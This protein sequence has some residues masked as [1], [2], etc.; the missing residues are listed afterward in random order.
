MKR[1]LLFLLLL[2]AGFAALHFALGGD[3]L[4]GKATR[5][6]EGPRLP[7]EADS[8]PAIKVSQGAEVQVRGGFTIGRHRDVARAE[9]GV[10]RQRIYELTCAD[11][12]AL[13]DGKHILREVRVQLFDRGAHA[14][15]LT[16]S[17]AV[18]ELAMDNRQQRSLRENRELE[19]EDAVLASVDGGRL[20]PLR[21]TVGRVLAQL[22]E[23]MIRLR[24]PSDRE[25]V[26]AVLD[27][28]RR[29]ELR[30][31]GLVASAPRDRSQGGLLDLRILHEPQVT[32]RGLQLRG[33]GELRYREDL[34][35]GMATIAMAGDIQADVEPRA[36]RGGSAEP[37]AVRG[38]RLAGLLQRSERGGSA[39]RSEL[40]WVGL[41]LF[42][43][44]ATVT[45][46]T[47]RIASPRL[48][49]LPGPDG[50][51]ESMIADG[52]ESELV[53][54]GP[55]GAEF[56]SRSP[57]RL[58]RTRSSI[59]ALHRSLGFPAHALGP[60]ADLEVLVFD[61]EASIRTD[62]GLAAT[63]SRGMRFYRR[64]NAVPDAPSLAL[65]FG[66]V[67]LAQTA[68]DDRIEATGGN[69]FV[70]RR[71][72]RG[73]EIQL[74]D[75]DP[76]ATQPF[77]IVR[78]G[79]ELRAQG[80]ATIRRQP[81]GVATLRL[82][83]AD[84]TI[85]GTFRQ[86]GREDVVHLRD[87]TALDAE[88]LAKEL[89]AFAAAGPRVAVD[90][91]R[92]GLTLQA[93]APR[94]ELL[95]PESWRLA[96][97][98]EAPARVRRDVGPAGRKNEFVG[99]LAAPTVLLHRVS[100]RSLAMEAFGDGDGLASIDAEDPDG[101][102]RLRANARRIV[103]LPFAVGPRSQVR[104]MLGLPPGAAEVVAGAMSQ[105]WLL[106]V[107]EVDAEFD[108][109]GQGSVLA[110]GLRLEAAL[111]S[112]A[113]LLHGDAAAR[114]PALLHRRENGVRTLTAEGPR[115]RF[116]QGAGERI[117]A[118]WRF[119]DEQEPLP[120][121]VTLYGESGQG[122]RSTG[123]ISGECQGEIEA[124][125]GAVEFRGPVTAHSLLPDGTVDPQGLAIDATRLRMVRNKATGTLQS[126]L[127]SE[128]VTLHW[129][130]LFA[131]SDKIEL[132][133]RWQRCIAEDPVGAEVRFGQGQ[134]Y[135]ARR[136]EANY[137]TY[138]VRSYFGS[139]QQ[140]AQAS[141]PR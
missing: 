103:L 19:L 55:K 43:Q 33:T 88:V 92:D 56:R 109:P 28:E 14:A 10:V 8:G 40:T 35:D 11:S 117:T 68:G 44:P 66:D 36:G 107:G 63:A 96:G 23:A 119:H 140:Q 129:N 22:D 86:P 69:G 29:G 111:G 127:A 13:P 116:A 104:S 120:P 42:G 30:G 38:Q 17:R 76:A 94:I 126:V 34:A 53:Q 91:V 118:L 83:S 2:G 50:G 95:T 97:S 130:D 71:D 110:E 122:A 112:Q 52:G 79:L 105:P 24:T 45:T 32:M 114:K 67:S 7:R 3:E 58:L 61:G 47:V 90:F 115:I 121:R 49:A 54:A 6:S 102:G 73:D 100:T 21:L 41:R 20:P 132:D 39:R 124:L 81:D 57:I 27:G 46:G 113:L 133:L 128:G 87:A 135:V 4:V 64:E 89:R 9:G 48:T 5:G 99:V 62:D 101:R 137:V 80:A 82:R 37:F 31:L 98:R 72:G 139:L 108:Q 26:T 51:I 141:A 65:G 1:L 74:G 125:P 18:V 93:D 25:P 12:E 59:A 136:I 131:Q 106:A 78:S 123:P 134:R 85:Q 138:T 70:L 84:A 16:A 77:A 15:D 75:G 60:V